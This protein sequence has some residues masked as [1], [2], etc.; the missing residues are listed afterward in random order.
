[1]KKEGKIF[2]T[3][4][5]MMKAIEKGIV[6]LPYVPAERIAQKWRDEQ[7]INRRKQ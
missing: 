3:F 5:C 6:K 2:T 7:L 4:L 1:M